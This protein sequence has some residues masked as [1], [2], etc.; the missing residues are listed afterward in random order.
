[1]A[2]GRSRRDCFL[3]EKALLSQSSHR[4]SCLHGRE[5]EAGEARA[6]GGVRV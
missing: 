4:E 1:M 3:S 6:Q 2:V 5:R